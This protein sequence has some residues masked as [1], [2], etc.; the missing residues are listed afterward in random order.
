MSNMDHAEYFEKL[1]SIIKI[2]ITNDLTIGRIE[3]DLQPFSYDEIQ[4]FLS[5]NSDIIQNVIKQIIHDYSIDNEIELLK[6]PLFD[7]I[8]E[9]LYDSIN[10]IDV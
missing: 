5:K 9:Y 1:E 10:T 4:L 8:G 3:N 7:W 2:M 6:N